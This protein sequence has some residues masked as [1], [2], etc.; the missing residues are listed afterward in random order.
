MKRQIPARQEQ[1]GIQKKIVQVSRHT[2]ARIE[3]KGMVK[4][5]S[6]Q[7]AVGVEGGW[8]FVGVGVFYGGGSA[9]VGGRPSY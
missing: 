1:K 2:T 5:G 4:T 8:F 9:G 6:E 7:A 3:N